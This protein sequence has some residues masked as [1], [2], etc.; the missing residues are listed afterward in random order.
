M[1]A[2]L[3]ANLPP[4]Y[5]DQRKVFTLDPDYFPLNRMREIVDYL[6]SHKQ[7]YGE[8]PY[9]SSRPAPLTA[10]VDQFS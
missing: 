4:D 1:H 2:S 9:F 5:M 10:H 8:H 3:K 6:H 7:Q